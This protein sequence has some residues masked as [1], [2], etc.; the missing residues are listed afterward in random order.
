MA[1]YV[2]IHGAASDSW[3]WHRVIPQLRALGRAGRSALSE[4]EFDRLRAEGRAL[5]DDEI[6]RLAFA[7][8]DSA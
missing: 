7:T 6:A 4:A 3:Y 8:D 1:T 2:L 5:R